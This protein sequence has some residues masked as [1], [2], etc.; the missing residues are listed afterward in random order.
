MTDDRQQAPAP[1]SALDNSEMLPVGPARP[2]GIPAAPVV[3]AGNPFRGR[4]RTLRDVVENVQP[5]DWLLTD[6]IARQEFCLVHGMPGAGKS[7]A[8][9]DLLL[10]LTTGMP[11]CG[12]RFQVPQPIRALYATGEGL[13]GV[14]ARLS[15]LAAWYG[16][17]G[18]DPFDAD[19]LL[20]IPEVPQLFTA[21]LPT[22]HRHLIAAIAEDAL[23]PIDLLV[24]DTL[25][26]ATLGADENHASDASRIVASIDNLRAELHCAVLVL[27]HSSKS[28]REARGSTAFLAAA[29]VALS[30]A[31]T[32][33]TTGTMRAEKLKDCAP[34]PDQEYAFRPYLDSVLLTWTGDSTA[35]AGGL[36]DAIIGLL[37]AEAGARMTAAEIAARIDAH[38]SNVAKA[39]RERLAGRVESGP[40]DPEQELHRTKN[41]LA[42]WI[43]A[44]ELRMPYHE[45]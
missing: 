36:S 6:L 35:R 15:A 19:R 44:R 21:D 17:S 1:G 32:S 22:S 34:F 9:L 14:Y 3:A 30:F 29:D 11:W 43:P 23:A 12:G 39:L 18:I 25:A 4:F 42:Y 2:C 5:A 8:A 45:D 38:S 26:S 13:R 7:L 20:V 10:A 33:E 24:V 37:Q 31:K 28:T 40:R 41:P 16:E 27:H